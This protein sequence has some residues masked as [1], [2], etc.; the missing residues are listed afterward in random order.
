VQNDREECFFLL[1]SKGIAEFRPPTV[2]FTEGVAELRPPGLWFNEGVA[3]LWRPAGFRRD[4]YG[5]GYAEQGSD[6]PAGAG[7]GLDRKCVVN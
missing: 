5:K 3:G 4:E 6:G 1:T 2:R 7:S